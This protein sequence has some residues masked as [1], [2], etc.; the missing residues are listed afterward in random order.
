MGGLR[1][2]LDGFLDELALGHRPRRHPADLYFP[3]TSAFSSSNQLR[4]T[5]ICDV[6]VSGRQTPAVTSG[7]PNRQ[8]RVPLPERDE[9]RVGGQ[10]RDLLRDGDRH[11]QPIEGIGM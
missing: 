7:R 11:E 4:T 8:A 6:T 2:K 5:L 9:A 3:P 1:A 10:Q